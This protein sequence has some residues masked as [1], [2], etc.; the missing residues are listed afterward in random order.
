MTRWRSAPPT[1]A[2]VARV[3]VERRRQGFEHVTFTG[4]EPTARSLLPRAL[5][6]AG[7]LG[8]R[9]YVTTNGGRFAEEA[10]ARAVLPF[11][12]E[13]CLSVHGADAAAHDA[14]A[15]TQ[16]SFARAMLALENIGRFGANVFLLTNTVVTRLNWEGLGD[17]LRV[18]LGRR[19]VRHCLVSNVAPEGRAARAYERLAVP[20]TS[21]RERVPR[22]ASLF[23]GKR[24]ALRF[25]G[26]PL[27]VL[28]GRRKLSNDAHFSP[29]VTIERR[30]VDG[31][32]GL[33][34]IPSFDASRRR[35]WA[36]VC[37]SCTAR[38]ECPGVFDQYLDAFGPAGLEALR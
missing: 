34:A 24:V 35:R 17:T 32:P 10:Y 7:S 2:E 4:G 15:R 12:D 1:A 9:T 26:L 8:L 5:R 31:A 19:A 18:L 16:G 13:L 21:W 33:A 22:L 25:F 36:E 29:R 20:L 6:A 3:L 23:R 38:S 30:S 14:C 28:G 37:A 27:C 11:I